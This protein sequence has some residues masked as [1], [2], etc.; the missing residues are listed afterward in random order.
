MSRGTRV[1]ETTS[2]KKK[3]RKGEG[4]IRGLENRIK[5]EKRPSVKRGAIRGENRI[6]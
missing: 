2:K 5:K 4:S 6:N 1:N 3:D